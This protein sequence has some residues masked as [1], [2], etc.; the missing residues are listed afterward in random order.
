M[1]LVKDSPPMPHSPTSS[2]LKR[3]PS[4][5]LKKPDSDS[6][7]PLSSSGKKP[8]V[9]RR[10]V[11]CKTCHTLKVKCS[12]SDPK[13][14]ASPCIRC[15]NAGRKCD[16]DLNQT[17]KRRKKAEILEARRLAEL[18][19]HQDSEEDEHDHE[20][21]QDD[22]SYEQLE[23]P[24]I[25]QQPKQPLPTLPMAPMNGF[26][27]AAE[28]MASLSLQSSV[29]STIQSPTRFD[30]ISPLLSRSQAGSTIPPVPSNLNPN[31]STSQSPPPIQQ[32]LQQPQ[33]QGLGQSPT[34]QLPS[35]YNGNFVSDGSA[36]PGTKDS[37]IM[38]LKQRVKFLESQLANRT[39]FAKIRDFDNMSDGQ[40]PPFVSKFDLE[41]EIN[42]LAESS[43]KLTDLTNQLNESASRRIQLVSEKEPVDLISKGIIS[44]EEAQERLILYREKIYLQHPVIQ[45]PNDISALDLL[46]TQP[47][48]FNSIMSATNVRSQ[49]TS[50]DTALAID[51]E[52]IK[53]ITIE[54]MVVGTKSVELVKA[55]LVLCLYYNSPEL[56]RQRRYHMLNTIC[57]SL[58]HDLG[59]FARPIYSFNQQEGTV[60]QETPSTEKMN[61][62]HRSLV[63]ITYFSTVS[64]CI[65]LRRSIYVKWTQ[66]V[67][68]CCSAL[69]N[70]PEE[71]YRRT[72]LFAR[73]NYMLE[74]IHQ[75]IHSSDAAERT[76]TASRYVIQEL[77]R[78]LMEL[79]QNI[80]PHQYALRS[81]YYS[82]EAYLHEPILSEVFNNENQLDTKAVKSLCI[83]TTSCLNALDEYS[84]LTP[85]DISLMP[86]SFGS[87]V[88]YTTGMLL[89][90]RYLILSLPSHIDK[91]LV[92]KRAVTTIQNVSKL[93][94]RANILN[95]TNHYLTKMRLV[96]QLFIQTY[97]T[98]VL[99]L[100][101]KN[102][103]TPQNFRPNDSEVR[104]LRALAKEYND[105]RDSRNPLVSDSRDSEPLD[106][107]SYAASF[108]R[109]NNFNGGAGNTASMFN[110]GSPGLQKSASDDG[111]RKRSVHYP[112]FGSVGNSPNTPAS[113]PMAGTLMNGQQQQQQSQQLPQQPPQGRP[114]APYH[115]F[116]DVVQP[117]GF[118]NPEYRNLRLPS[119]SNS[120][121]VNNLANPDQL[122]NS[123]LVLNDEF[124]SNL[125]SNDSTTD[126]INFTS[127]NFNGNLINDEVFFMN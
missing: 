105:V 22:A 115:Q 43:A 59:I 98:Q 10:S 1:S 35:P 120:V 74:K 96:L 14:P 110:N 87:R 68:E 71:K 106:V 75:L 86:F 2:L 40:S 48:L 78:S 41:S 124:W 16:I 9:T 63:L 6:E 95:P 4:G 15:V 39:Q 83:C 118:Q 23:Q 38:Q 5:K 31:S 94:E 54:V 76:S 100:L 69:E 13:N 24:H 34:P 109:D 55:F 123:Y 37:E 66:Y 19:R 51:N 25:S 72:A 60:R 65:V 64:I 45:I 11:A 84:K 102:G 101:R 57:V 73:M 27:S 42:T 53:S 77:Q 122:E 18:Q 81:Y 93:V 97:A 91:E 58:L 111:N 112:N 29:Q 61:D 56:F 108:R 107:L 67:E 70:S 49:Y 3:S 46:R 85:D 82:I 80:K 28:S 90:L 117:G 17:R 116:G 88:M 47:F 89:R 121:H 125:L 26:L 8:K 104:Q 99:E 7:A 12:P 103:S 126:R 114:T 21:E 32:G 52:A 79:K 92:P 113:T 36:S 50:I 33:Q 119:I 127:N 20:Q 62:E 44:A 30:L